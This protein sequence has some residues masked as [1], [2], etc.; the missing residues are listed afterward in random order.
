MHGCGLQNGDHSV[1]ES[2]VLISQ[3]SPGKTEP[4]EYIEILYTDIER[5]YKRLAN[6]MVEAE[7]SH[8]LPYANRRTRRSRDLVPV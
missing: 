8:D 1:C 4:M 6:A 7:K 3:D 5:D 2:W